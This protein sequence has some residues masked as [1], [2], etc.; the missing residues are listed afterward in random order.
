MFSERLRSL[1]PMFGGA[2]SYVKSLD[3]ILNYADEQQPTTEE[4]VGWHRGHFARVSSQKSIMR[5][6]D[7]L[8]DVGLLTKNGQ[9]W[10]LGPEGN[11]YITDQSTDTL[12]E[13]MC[14]RNI[15][16]RSLLY[17]LSASPMTIEEISRQ[18]LRTHTELGWD[19]KNNDMALQRVNWLRSLELVQKDGSQYALTDRGRQF[20]DEAIEYWSNT[21]KSDVESSIAAETYETT[22]TA[23][24]IDPEFREVTL[25]R[26]DSTC[27]ISGVDHSSLLDVAHVLSWRDH[28]E[29]RADLSNVLALSK[30]HHAAF[31]RELFTIDQN[32]RIRVNPTFET[33][34]DLLQRTIVNRDGE[35]ISVSD[36][37][38]NPD[39]ITQHNATLEWV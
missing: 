9:H 1:V 28:P 27:P 30:T 39:Y 2:T 6:I 38:V 24:A 5:R 37:T 18:Q 29:Y 13:I 25:K 32:Y 23:R 33:E 19:P 22:V 3:S 11:R 12:L 8:E 4:L 7:Y 15:G 34:S 20:T 31:D 26:F 17:S 14:R 36:G 16:L 21:P 10:T 35:R